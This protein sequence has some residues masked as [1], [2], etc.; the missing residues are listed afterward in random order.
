M[1]IKYPWTLLIPDLFPIIFFHFRV[2][3]FNC[4]TIPLLNRSFFLSFDFCRRKLLINPCLGKQRLSVLFPFFQCI[5]VFF[6]FPFFTYSYCL[7]FHLLCYSGFFTFSTLYAY[8]SVLRSF[9][10]FFDST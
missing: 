4:T 2:I 9:Y 1:W 6:N 7:L 5:F 8:C 3:S 10:F